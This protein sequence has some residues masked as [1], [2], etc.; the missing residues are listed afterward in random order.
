MK[1]IQPE[2]FYIADP[3]C[4]WCWGFSPVIGALHESLGGRVRT[5][6][7]A[8]GLRVGGS[9]ALTHE[10]KET[11]LHHWHEVEDQTGQ[12]FNFDFDMPEGF[13]YNTEPSCRA[14]VTVRHAAEDQSVG[15]RRILLVKLEQL[16]V[17]P[18]LAAARL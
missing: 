5:S 14:A 11:V 2:L 7:V 10:I 15:A 4:S 9:H 8:G 12:P 3:M 17:G 18:R 6:L 16:D 1:P 13:I